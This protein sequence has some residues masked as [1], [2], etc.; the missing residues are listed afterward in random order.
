MFTMHEHDGLRAHT[1]R[2]AV[3]G[4]SDAADDW[5]QGRGVPEAESSVGHLRDRLHL[6][7]H[8]DDLCG[9]DTG[10]TFYTPYS[11]QGSNHVLITGLGVFITGSRPF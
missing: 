10:W 3:L 11:T 9:V 8:G 4:N 2:L 7:R 1:C 5:R 6:Y